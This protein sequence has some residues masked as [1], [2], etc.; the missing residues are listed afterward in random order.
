MTKMRKIARVGLRWVGR[1]LLVLVLCT[2]MLVAFVLFTAAGTRLAL[3]VGLGWYNGRIPGSIAIEE[4]EGRL[5]DRLALRGVSLLDSEGRALITAEAIELD[6][7]F[8]GI[9]RGDVRARELRVLRPRVYLSDD[10]GVPAHFGD[11]AIPGESPPRSPLEPPGPNLPI[12]LDVPLVLED[13]AV[14]A[15]APLVQGAGLRARLFASGRVASVHLE[16]GAASLP[17]AELRDLELDARWSSPVAEVSRLRALADGAA[18]RIDAARFDV[19]TFAGALA[20]EA[21]AAIGALAAAKL[22]TSV[23]ETL[24]KLGPTAHVAIDAV[25]VPEDTSLELVVQALPGLDLRLGVDGAWEGAPWARLSLDGDVDLTA[26]TGQPLGRARPR[27]ELGVHT[28]D[29]TEELREG[30]RAVAE[31][32]VRCDDCGAVGPLAVD[33]RG[34]AEL[35]RGDAALHVDLAAAGVEAMADL[36]AIGGALRELRWGLSI[37]DL[38]R[39]SAIARAFAAGVPALRGGLAGA[40][41]CTGPDLHCGGTLDARRLEVKGAEVDAL[42]VAFHAQP[43]LPEGS[44]SITIRGARRGRDQLAGADLVL[45]VRPALGD[46]SAGPGTGWTANLPHLRADLQ[47]ALWRELPG[48][49]DRGRLDLSV[50]TGD[51]IW[52]ELRTLDLHYDQAAVALLRRAE[53]RV[54]GRRVEVDDLGLDLG[55]G[56][57]RVDGA[58]DLDG[59]SDLAVDLEDFALASLQPVLP[60]TRLRGTVSAAA[61]LRGAASDPA[62]SLKASVQGVAVGRRRIGDVAAD[63][64]LQGG[65]A[66]AGVTLT[67]SVADRVTLD[68]YAPAR[69]D[70]SAGTFDMPRGMARVELAVKGLHLD[71]LR[72][73]LPPAT[74]IPRGEV[75]LGVLVEGPSDAL[76][77]NAVLHARRLAFRGAGVGDVDAMVEHRGQR[78]SGGVQLRRGQARAELDFLVP[79]LADVQRRRFAWKREE[80]HEIHLRLREFDVK[81]QLEPLAP[82]HD[83]IGH[84]DL[85]AA[86]TGPATAPKIHATLTGRGIGAKGVSFGSGQV[87]AEVAEGHAS[88]RIDLAGGAVGS[89]RAS[90]DAPLGIGAN[91]LDWRRRE[92]HRAE[93]HLDKFDLGAL[94]PL[95]GVPF[96]GQLATDLTLS[97]GLHDPE[98]AGSIRGTH[99]RFNRKPIGDLRIDLDWADARLAVKGSARFSGQHGKLTLDGLAPLALDLDGGQAV[100]WVE[101]RKALVRLDADGIDH[102]TLATLAPLPEETLVNADIHLRAEMD[103]KDVKGELSLDGKMGHKVFGATPVKI[104]ANVDNERQTA[105]FEL[106]PHPLSG[107]ITAK[108]EARASVPA[109][110]RGALDIK[111]VPLRGEVRS[112]GV[113]LR[114]LNMFVPQQLYDLVGKMTAQIDIGGRL[115]APE[116]RGELKLRKGGVTIVPMQQRIRDVILDARADGPKIT[117]SRLEATSGEGRLKSSASATIGKGKLEAAADATLTRFPIVRPGLPQM[118]VDTKVHASVKQDTKRSEVAIEVARAKVW[119]TD[120]TTRAPKAIPENENVVIVTGPLP[121][122]QAAVGSQKALQADHERRESELGEVEQAAVD[123]AAEGRVLALSVDLKEPV[124][125]RGNGINMRWGG[126]VAVSQASEERSVKGELVAERGSKFSLLGTE[127]RIDRGRVF[128][129]PQGVTVDPYLDIV[130]IGQKPQAEVTATVRGRVSRPEL[131]LS[132]NP[133]LTEPQILSLLV[134]GTVEPGEGNKQSIDAKAANLLANFSNPALSRYLDRTLGIDKIQV[135]FGAD[136]TQPILTVGRR[137]SEK[138]YA[139]TSYHHNAPPRENRVEARVEYYFTPAWSLESSY[140]TSAVGGVDV[141]WRKTFGL[142]RRRAALTT[143]KTPSA[144]SSS[145]PS[146]SP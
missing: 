40:G 5:S 56:R 95:I 125:I 35:P 89:L 97:G 101:G 116:I 1:S 33:L 55:R 111:Q 72:G 21:D 32:R 84:V 87:R 131:R 45:A 39:P 65:R 52:A 145:T 27:V 80:A 123:T 31:G 142:G 122:L 121:G 79:L 119:V 13:G 14:L 46:L 67:R 50:Q 59:E 24:R 12:G 26:L 19:K 136:I 64:S 117:V 20:L 16:D 113:D 57:L 71:K 99:L 90:A 108:A 139:E 17:W 92:P 133:P 15:G 93:V 91:G 132:S 100:R 47:G 54:R 53:V 81:S 120:L 2:L 129:P 98:I 109:L 138:L 75:D 110:R 115:G 88:A 77:A 58:F 118:Q 76:R 4:I 61:R 106:G 83:L 63:A 112:P 38:H 74:E 8:W 29:P 18:L 6:W 62:L 137:I 124:E 104:R 146:P 86:V 11:L 66:S 3:T 94:R 105:S 78:L 96:E 25:A 37:L 128:L 7:Y 107:R 103:P 70:L 49:G 85:E 69:V 140:G 68:A 42:R 9:L 41:L 127:F 82:G 10:H 73:W 130:A 144:S 44:A 114:Y 48:R 141:F 30:T 60:R 126:K 36:Q 134:T 23:T 22:P 143:P 135:G 51:A 28:T 102:I 43:T 34:S